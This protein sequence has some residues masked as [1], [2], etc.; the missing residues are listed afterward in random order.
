MVQVFAGEREVI[1]DGSRIQSPCFRVPRGICGSESEFARSW[2]E[3]KV[4]RAAGYHDGVIAHI[5]IRLKRRKVDSVARP[6]SFAYWSA[7][8]P[9][10]DLFIADFELFELY[11]NLAQKVD[12]EIFIKGNAELLKVFG[13]DLGIDKG[14]G[15][16][17]V[18]T[19]FF[20]R[21]S[22]R[23]CVSWAILRDVRRSYPGPLAR[24]T[25]SPLVEAGLTLSLDEMLPSGEEMRMKHRLEELQHIGTGSDEDG[26][27]LSQ[28]DLTLFTTSASV[29]TSG[30]AYDRYKDNLR[31]LLNPHGSGNPA[32][33]VCAARTAISRLLAWA[34]KSARPKLMEGH[35]RVEWLCVSTNITRA[36][37]IQVCRN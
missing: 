29:L 8:R 16:E 31:C 22:E 15:N 5:W 4:R 37:P 20:R 30:A 3:E 9:V 7:I 21:R 6:N 2:N 24:K 1:E 33:N 27:E 35:Q 17:A 26:E 34:K 11:Y 13:L 28:L 14:D 12:D 36:K 23:I 25:K 18:A 10:V 32:G 19:R